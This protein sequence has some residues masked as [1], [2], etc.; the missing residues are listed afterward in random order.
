M[1]EIALW[2][3]RAL[4]LE[5]DAILLESVDEALSALGDPVK[6]AIYFHLE[7]SFGIRKDEIPQRLA[8]FKQALE[9][10]LG[11]H[12]C[13]GGEFT[14]ILVLKKLYEKVGEVFKYTNPGEIA[15]L[16]YVATAKF[17]FQERSRTALTSELASDETLVKSGGES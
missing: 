1:L 11:A 17:A 9:N 14:E 2:G 10:I 12:A 7:Q 6:R 13:V 8:D 15:F 3:R 4:E 5:F 16:Q